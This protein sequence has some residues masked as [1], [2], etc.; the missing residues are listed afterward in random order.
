MILT[1]VSRLLPRAGWSVLLPRPET[2]LRW[3]RELV[4]RKWAAF[5]RR[6]PRRKPPGDPER[7]ALILQ[8]AAENPGWGY[9][10]IQ[11]EM[12]KLGYVI[13]HT[14]IAKLLRRNRIPPAPRRHDCSWRAFLRQHAAQILATDF[15][16][17]ET[18]WLKRLYVLFFIEH[19]TRTVHLA[20]ITAHPTGDWMVQQARNLAWKL[21]DG[22][23]VRYLL[24]DRDT[25]Y[26]AG[27][28]QVLRSE[29]ADVIRLPFRAPR[30]NDYALDCTSLA[31]CG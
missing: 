18:A 13:S 2:L 19:A 17:V 10:R 3:H 30:A 27:F 5:S 29:G 16:T 23:V 21:Q 9:R 6:P 15:F 25:K 11:G 12:L 22:L 1:I 7:R 31:C 24:R 20:G 14:S 4:R 28:D 8:L 26:T